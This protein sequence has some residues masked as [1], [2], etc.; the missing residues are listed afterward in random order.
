MDNV[1]KDLEEIKTKINTLYK[2]AN[3]ARDNLVF[4]IN[5][6]LEYL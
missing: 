4:E 3:I 6:F 1:N 5:D 2:E